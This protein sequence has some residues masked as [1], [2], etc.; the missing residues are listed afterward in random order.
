MTPPEHDT[1]EPDPRDP[2]EQ[3][4]AWFLR[5]ANGE[6]SEDDPEFKAWLDAS[7]ENAEA[8]SSVR[9]AWGAMGQHANAPEMQVARRDALADAT[10][11]AAWR[12]G[13]LTPVSRR[14]KALA[15]AVALVV[16]VAPMVIWRTTT[17]DDVRSVAIR[18]QLFDTGVG[19]TRVV[20]L[21]D[22]SKVSL[23]ASTRL[24]VDYGTA[25]REIVLSHGQAHFDVAKD[26]MRPFLVTAADQAVMAT[27]T[28]F[29]VELVDDELLVTLIEGEVIV[30]DARQM[31]DDRG[32]LSSARELSERAGGVVMNPGEQL[33]VSATRAAAPAITAQADIEKATAW[34]RGMVMLDDDTLTNAVARMNRY[35]QIRLV[36]AD[37]RLDELKIS[38]IFSTGD[39][40]AFVEALEAYFPVRAHR[41]SATR[42]EL[43]TRG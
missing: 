1:V 31:R 25:S 24:S 42:I 8:L 22:N 6:I 28:A 23:D 15:A 35:S 17:Q 30:A 11:R 9:V 27:G 4:A 38:G 16:V 14:A 36:V 18:P 5:V 41:V 19:E 2:H 37:E 21:S 10:R 43:H 32:G 13:A 34:R 20:T 3:A 33:I 39:V 7:P 26:P 12:W 29:N 40:D